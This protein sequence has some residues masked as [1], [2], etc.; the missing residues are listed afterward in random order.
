MKKGIII[1]LLAFIAIST[2][3]QEKK[4][5][6]INNVKLS[7]YGIV[8][9]QSSSQEDA[10]S[11]SF[12]LRIARVSL[13]GRVLKDFYWKAQIQF[14]GNTST[15]GSSPKVV[16]LFAE[17][18]KYDFFRVKI[19][20]FKNP[21]TYENPMNPIDQGFMGYSQ[22]VQKLAGFSDRA[23]AHSSNGRDIGLQFQGDFLK[24]ANGRNLIHYQVGVFNGQ[25]INVK[26]VDE[27]KNI[28]GGVWVMPVPGMRL[29]AFGWTG[30]YARKGTWTDNGGGSG[31]RK[32]QQRR[33]AFSAE[34]FVD[35][36]TFRSEYA[37]STGLAFSKALSNTNDATSTNCDLGTDGDKAQGV[38]ALVIAP[39]VK[40]K[41]HVKARYDMYQP[42]GDSSKQKTLYE[43]GADYLFHKNFQIGAEYAF[44]ND[45]SLADHNYGIFDVEVSFR[46]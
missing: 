8:Q 1:A 44:V 23:G 37:H 4:Q 14:N 3:A 22:V 45:R 16:D 41:V 29:G 46:F 19:G 33:Y 24:N 26:D 18:Q 12:N 31:V 40:Q 25:G 6:W 13:D 9:Y 17:W 15:L 35:D 30:S 36:W 21:F 2:N 39:V 20:Q 28:I 34:Y 11:N 42:T 10:K 38:Y 43:I 32:L 7:G 27:Q 5:A